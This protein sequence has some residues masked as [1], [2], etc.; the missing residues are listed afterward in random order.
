ML[1][2]IFLQGYL[3]VYSIGFSSALGELQTVTILN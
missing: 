1:K 2:V 3:I